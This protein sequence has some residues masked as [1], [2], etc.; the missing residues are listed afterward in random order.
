MKYTY[1]VASL[2]TLSLDTLPPI[3]FETFLRW[4]DGVL[5]Q[6]DHWELQHLLE[7]NAGACVSRFAALWFGFETPFRRSIARV[8]AG[9]LGLNPKT[10]APDGEEGDPRVRQGVLDAFAKS[11]PREREWII[12]NVR[13]DVLE[14]LRRAEPFGLSEVLAFALQLQLAHRWAGFSVEKGRRALAEHEKKL[15]PADLEVAN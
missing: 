14:E 1:L 7:G 4:C 9:R 6:R 15:M 8:R 12:D 10:A 13:W 2:P 5:E 11:N 3:Q